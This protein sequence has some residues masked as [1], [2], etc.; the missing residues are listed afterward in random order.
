MNE[1]TLFEVEESLATELQA[2]CAAYS[3][4]QKVGPCLF[5]LLIPV[6]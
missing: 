2:V 3:H 4:D 1:A 6:Y 5:Y